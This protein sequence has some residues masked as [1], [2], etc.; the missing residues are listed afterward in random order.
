MNRASRRAVALI[1]GI[2]ALVGLGSIWL[3]RGLTTSSPPPPAISVAGPTPV[4]TLDFF[5]GRSYPTPTAQ[6]GP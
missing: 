2:V 3:S 1:V 5:R 6:P 4:P